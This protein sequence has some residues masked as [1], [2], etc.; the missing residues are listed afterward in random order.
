[1]IKESAIQNKTVDEQDEFLILKAL[2]GESITREHLAFV[3]C[4]LHDWFG[5]FVPVGGNCGYAV[6]PEH[7]HPSY[8]FVIP[9][10]SES[11]VYVGDKRIETQP[12]TLVCISPEVSHHE[13]QNYFPPKY[14]A[15]CIDKTRFEEAFSLYTNDTPDFRGKIAEVRTQRLDM[16]VQE[17][18]Q[19]SHNRH[20]SRK[21]VLENLSTLLT[22]EII[23]TIL[24]RYADDRNLST[25]QKINE[26]V[27]FIRAHYEKNI[28]IEEMAQKV[29]LSKSHFTKLF[30]R[31]MQTAPMEY[32]KRIRLQNAKKM[33]LSGQLNVTQV[34]ER[35][36]FNSP[37]YFTKCFKEAYNETPM[38]FMRRVK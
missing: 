25:H 20:F 29:S 28:S 5:L 23:R 10:D 16:L 37:S 34:A 14:C 17:F 6:T 3:D 27:V 9:Y 4:F 19:E 1:M 35:C 24:G 15:I 8:M 2:V 22:H 11:V 21:I 36:G 32:L 13:V 26:A 31:S 18:I 30:T 12:D 38:E 33:L 7:T